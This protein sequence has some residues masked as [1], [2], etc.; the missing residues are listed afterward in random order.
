MNQFRCR[1]AVFAFVLPTLALAAA[2]TEIIFAGPTVAG[3][4]EAPPRNETSGIA[5]SRQSDDLLWTHD[6][7][8]G[9]PA[10][11]AVS[12]KGELRGTLQI[13]GVPSGDWEDIS[14]TTIDN[15]PW[16][17]I[18]DI[19]DNDARRKLITLYFV[20]EPSAAEL[21][22]SRS[23]SAEPS[24]RLHLRFPDGPRDCE[25]LAIDVKERAVY[26]LSKRDLVPRL[27]RASLPAKLSN[28]SEVVAEFVGPTPEL[29]RPTG[30]DAFFA[31]LFEKGRARPCGMDFSP[32][33]SAAV[34]ITYA[35]VVVYPRGS[36]DS[37]AEAFA[38]APVRLG[39]HSLPQAEAVCFSRNG[40]SIF[41][42]SEET[43]Q[44]LRYDRR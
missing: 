37:W 39:A 30:A 3:E 38:R 40:T 20:A 16:L 6:D 35:D 28:S 31:A 23:L 9:A 32:D 13:R 8:G 25:S 1:V 10:L 12:T 7:S 17:V 29:A 24:A 33:G 11:Y 44:L 26:L 14:C 4:L 34:V 41:A 18:G 27:Y 43:R 42:A 19:G 5:A 22:R 15:V 2:S 36:D 21:K